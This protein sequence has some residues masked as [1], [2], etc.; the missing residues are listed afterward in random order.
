M[1]LLWMMGDY[2]DRKHD[3]EPGQRTVWDG[4]A[5]LQMGTGVLQRACA[6]GQDSEV[7]QYWLEPAK[8]GP[9]AGTS[10]PRRHATGPHRDSLSVPRARSGTSFYAF[11]SPNVISWSNHMWL[12]DRLLGRGAGK[13][14]LVEGCE[15]NA[16][17][18]QAALEVFVVVE[19][20]FGVVREVRAALEEQRAE[21]LVEQVESV[22]VG[23]GGRGG[24][25]DRALPGEGIDRGLGAQHARLL[26]HLADEQ[27][28]LVA[29]MP[30][31]VLP[32]AV[33]HALAV[34]EAQE[35]EALAPAEALD[36]GDEVAGHG[37]HQG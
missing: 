21:V 28:A 10:R 27:H 19:A 31:E 23:P 24:Q 18:T 17:L 34:S 33:V 5:Y 1:K 11:K 25:A 26:P 12:I 36:D 32:G 13:Q 2:L 6:T 20:Q 3:P 35:V 16:Q 37:G 15:R 4:Y 30:G 22:G 9:E 29:G 14:A 7:D 8:A